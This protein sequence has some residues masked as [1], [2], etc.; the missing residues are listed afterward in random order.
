MAQKIFAARKFLAES[1][2]DQVGVV[3]PAIA[4]TNCGGLAIDHP[5]QF[6]ENVTGRRDESCRVAQVFENSHVR[7]EEPRMPGLRR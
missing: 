4:H 5:G 7:F 1:L 2:V 3:S 6:G